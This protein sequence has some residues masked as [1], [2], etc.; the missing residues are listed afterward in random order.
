L[1]EF[2]G[3]SY[4]QQQGRDFVRAYFRGCIRPEAARQGSRKCR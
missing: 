4:P 2:R 3:F 1:A